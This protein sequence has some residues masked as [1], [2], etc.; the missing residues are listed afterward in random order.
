MISF[1][2]DIRVRYGEVDQMGFLYHANYV[3]YFDAARTEMIRDLGVSNFELERE[4]V[5]IPV[6]E[7]NVKYGKPAHYDDVLT[8]RTSIKERP[9]I[10][11][12]FH[13]EVLRGEEC[14]TTGSVTVAFMNSTTKSA[15]RPPK[16]LIDIINKHFDEYKEK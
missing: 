4:G 2:F 9:R 8:I 1:D 10:K 15:C 5:M 11:T 3:N 7:V 6:L 14:L 16:K 12:T 13:Y